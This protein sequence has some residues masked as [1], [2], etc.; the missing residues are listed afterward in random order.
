MPGSQNSPN[1]TIAFARPDYRAR[2]RIPPQ[3]TRLYGRRC[4][5][6]EPDSRAA[7]HYLT[8]VS[9]AV[10]TYCIRVIT[11]TQTFP[12]HATVVRMDGRRASPPS[13]FCC[14]RA[15]ATGA[16][17]DLRAMS[18]CLEKV[19]SFGVNLQATSYTSRTPVKLPAGRLQHAPFGH[20]HYLHNL[21]PAVMLN[22]PC[23][24]PCILQFPLYH[25]LRCFVVLIHMHHRIHANFQPNV[26]YIYYAAHTAACANA[27]TPHTRATLP[28]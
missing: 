12:P 11:T 25:A 23:G 18:T 21:L 6:L 27:P 19:L 4:S 13:A 8:A 7:L 22:A 5:I 26:P 2:T 1:S 16:A 3:A 14:I 28:Y 24:L 9:N 10:S 20:A 17:A 15:S